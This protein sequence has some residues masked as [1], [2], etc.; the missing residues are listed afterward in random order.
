MATLDAL[1]RGELLQA[2]EAAGFE[3]VRRRTLAVRS[4]DG[5]L[6]WVIAGKQGPGFSV[7]FAIQ[8]LW[9]PE[10]HL[11]VQPGGSIA[12]VK[13][14][15]QKPGGAQ[16]AQCDYLRGE[17]SI[18]GASRDSGYLWAMD[19]QVVKPIVRAFEKIVLPWLDGARDAAGLVAVLARE[20]WKSHHH[21]NFMRGS[22]LARLDR[23]EDSLAALTAAIAGYEEDLA[24]RPGAT[25]CSERI[26]RCREL[27]SALDG[28]AHQPLLERWAET[29][30]AALLA[31]V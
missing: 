11:V 4:H 24:Q 2:L 28:G 8:P 1:F 23:R 14:P 27:A 30:R 22:A 7:Q 26:E 16:V 25:W 15:F 17:P 29:T 19:P 21:Q 12:S 31:E 10:Q 6:Q 5:I 3:R 20:E 9:V 13:S 18:V